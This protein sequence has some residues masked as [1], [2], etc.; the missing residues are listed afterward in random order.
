MVGDPENPVTVWQKLA[1]Q[2]QKK[3]WANKLELRR[4]LYAMCLKEGES[5]QNQ[6]KVMT[7]IFKALAVIGDPVS[8]EDRVVHLLA[9]LPESFNMLVTA[10][11]ANL[12]VPKMENVT[13]RLLHEE[14]KMIGREAD[15]R[16]QSKAMTAHNSFGQKKKF[17]CHYCERPGHLK[18]NCRKLAFELANFNAEKKEKTGFKA[19]GKMKHKANSATSGHKNDSNSS[20]DDDDALVVC[21]ALSAGSKGNWIVDS[22]ATCHMCNDEKLF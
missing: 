10:L 3:T 13:E 8:E 18:W 9:S 20:S 11:E 12:E 14:R 19:K 2:F 22:G 6:V 17:T 15:E 7:E 21:H 5:V 16:E 1:D 4:K